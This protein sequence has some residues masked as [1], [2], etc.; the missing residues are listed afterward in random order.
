MKALA[1]ITAA[2]LCAIK[3]TQSVR[4]LIAIR[5]TARKLDE[6]HAL[7]LR[8]QTKIKRCQELHD[9]TIESMIIDGGTDEN[10]MLSDACRQDYAEV[11]ELIRQYESM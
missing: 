11:Q 3:I 8:I 4:R 9:V 6:K 7:A 10:L 5:H 2:A 1:I